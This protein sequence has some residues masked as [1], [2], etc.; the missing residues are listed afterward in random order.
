MLKNFCNRTVSG[1]LLGLL[2]TVFFSLPLS[3]AEQSSLTNLESGL[4]ELIYDLS[5]SVVTVEVIAPIYPDNL[6][7]LT[8]EAVYSLVSTGL[9]YDSAGHIITGAGSVSGR[10]TIVVKFENI[11]KQARLMAIDHQS[12]LALLKVDRTFGTPITMVD[13]PGCAG[14]MVLAVG[15][16]YGL[17]VSPSIGFCTG[18]RSDG[19][20]QFSGSFPSGTLGGGLFTL[21]GELMGLIS[22]SLGQNGNSG[23]GLAIPAW[24]I[25]EIVTYLIKNG[26]RLAG[27]LGLSSTEIEINPPIEITLPMQ[28]YSR[29]VNNRQRL[30]STG[31]LVTRVVP[32]SPA[33]H[34]GLQRGDIL[35]RIDNIP[36]TSAIELMRYV[37][38]RKPGTVIEFDLLRHNQP[39]KTNLPLGSHEYIGYENDISMSPGNNLYQLQIDSL[40][41]E[42]NRIKQML[43]NFE[44]KVK[45]LR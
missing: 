36:I 2:L 39:Y 27:Y 15:N 24:N 30:V 28:E 25:D 6:I 7:G 42:M 9:I 14:Q 31:V 41:N 13:E 37:K 29:T 23:T 21:K 32:N 16:A 8:D 38:E 35:Y 4:N 26:S 22:G 17:R 5:R 18:S 33:Y 12:G 11:I 43:L 34:A 20:I 40:E 44:N 10:T 1:V 45:R 19:N 3:A